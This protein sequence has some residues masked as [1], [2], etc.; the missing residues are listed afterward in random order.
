MSDPL[1]IAASIA[2]LAALTGK[3]FKAFIDYGKGVKDAR[4]DVSILTTELRTLSGM[5]TNLSLLATSLEAPSSNDSFFSNFQLDALKMIIKNLEVKLAVAKTDFEAS[6]VRSVI[7]K[8]RWPFSKDDMMKWV[9]EIRAHKATINL[10]LSADTLSNLVLCLKVQGDIRGELESTRDAMTVLQEMYSRVELNLERQKTYDYFLKINP[11]SQFETA[12]R[13]RNSDTGDWFIKHRV[14]TQWMVQPNS[15][16]WLTGIPGSGK[17]LLCGLL[18]ERVLNICT[19][20]TILAFSFCDY[21]DPETQA[22]GNILSSIALQIGLQKP[23]AFTR[24]QEYYKE[25]HPTSGLPRQ[26][27]IGKLTETIT[28]I[29]HLFTKVF[30]IVDGL[31]ECINNSR[32]ITRG[33]AQLASS[34]PN[35][36]IA[37]FSR[38][39]I[40]IDSELVP[41][42][43]EIEISAQRQDLERYIDGEM[44]GRPALRGLPLDESQKIKEALISKANGMFRW[45]TCQLDCLEGLGRIGRENALHE[46]PPTLDESYDRILN[47]VMSKRGRKVAQEIVRNTLHWVCYDSKCLSIAQICEAL[48]ITLSRG[49]TK[50]ETVDEKEILTYCS[51]LIRKNLKGDRFELAHFTVE[52]YLNAIDDQST[53]R[54]FRY[55]E[56]DAEVSL[57][58]VSLEH[59]LSPTFASRPVAERSECEKVLQRRRDHPFYGYAATHWPAASGTHDDGAVN[60]LLRDLFTPRKRQYLH[61]WLIE[62]CLCHFPSG[63]QFDDT[64]YNKLMNVI[65]FILRQDLTALH[66]AAM[67]CSSSL[68]RW[69]LSID[70]DVNAT[71]FSDLAPI[72]FA[73]LGLKVF[74]GVGQGPLLKLASCS[75]KNTHNSDDLCATVSTL[76]EHGFKAPEV[77]RGSV[78]KLALDACAERCGGSPFSAL[79]AVFPDECLAQDALI[80]IVSLFETDTLKNNLI[81]EVIQA[82]FSLDGGGDRSPQV[83]GAL[84][85]VSELVRS[86]GSWDT[87]DHAEHRFLP[88][89]IQDNDFLAYTRYTAQQNRAHDM[90]RLID[91][92]RFHTHFKPTGYIDRHHNPLLTAAAY[93][94][95]E[96]VRVLLQSGFDWLGVEEYGD[97][98]WHVAS[99]AGSLHVLQTLLGHEED[100]GRSLRVVSEGNTPLG[101]AFEEGC[102]SAATL[103]MGYCTSD[104]RFF[105]CKRNILSCAVEM[106]S[107]R[108][109]HEL[110]SRGAPDKPSAEDAVPL[111]FVNNHCSDEFVEELL[112]RY[113]KTHVTS[114][115]S[116]VFQA[117]IRQTL[118]SADPIL[119]SVE[120]LASRLSMLA[121][122]NHMVVRTKSKQHIWRLV[123]QEIGS[124]GN[125]PRSASQAFNIVRLI[126][127]LVQAGIVKSFEKRGYGSSMTAIYEELQV[128]TFTAGSHRWEVDFIDQASSILR[129]PPHIIRQPSTIA[130]LTR[131]IQ[132]RHYPI[133][134]WLLGL[135][136]PVHIRVNGIAP[137]EQ[138]CRRR[139]FRVFMEV[140]R[141]GES[142]LG[143]Q[144]QEAGL[145]ILCRLVEAA[146]E[147]AGYERFA[148]MK[149]R[150]VLDSGLC[151]DEKSTHGSRPGEPAIVM[152]ARLGEFDI[153]DLLLANGANIFAQASD[154][155]DLTKISISENRINLL[156]QIHAKAR[157]SS[158]CDWNPAIPFTYVF[159]DISDGVS[160]ANCSVLHLAACSSAVEIIDYLFSNGLIDNADTCMQSFYTP[161]HVASL[162][163]DVETIRCLVRHGASVDG[164]NDKQKRPI[165]LAIMYEEHDAVEILRILGAEQAT[166]MIPASTGSQ[167]GTT[168]TQEVEGCIEHGGLGQLQVLLSEDRPVDCLMPTCG[169]CDILTYAIY[170]GKSDIVVWL[171]SI[172]AIPRQAA[173]N[174]HGVF[175]TLH[176]AVTVSITG[177]CLR[178]LLDKA[179]QSGYA[180]SDSPV[181]PLHLA[182]LYNDVEALEVILDH[183]NAN[184]ERYCASISPWKEQDVPSDKAAMAKALTGATTSSDCHQLGEGWGHMSGGLMLLDMTSYTSRGYW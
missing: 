173:C 96:V 144:F 99:R 71:T 82:I 83:A 169:V 3:V 72:H 124:F 95:A 180:W 57:A 35:L 164:V 52:E 118:A 146:T 151:V 149:I 63:D 137:I 145:D 50:V 64:T 49:A 92:A 21:K 43:D 158:G 103:L 106:G 18:I 6:K 16:M 12:R 156:R 94:N 91:D 168:W 152:A 140:F 37:L 136:T 8:L 33:I 69:L 98:V 113:D 111:H 127:G 11:Q 101:S 85:L 182:C 121:P 176:Q 66:I 112:Q 108:L 134:R 9:D 24:L 25:L 132:Q 5:L 68:C 54:S 120:Q 77:T 47:K 81:H 78:G 143:C 177:F 161:L 87:Y 184:A 61:N 119:L 115:G 89:L 31:D 128:L 133:M 174:F 51:S 53:L 155:L 175:G 181:S 104:V 84:R 79:L 39:E 148:M 38:R 107:Q 131:A 62:F 32:E 154:G 170:Y 10:A 147:R 59:I 74:E 55:S 45:V 73:L 27:D 166:T 23:D 150:F 15:R 14:V 46:L 139:S 17:T 163:G 183:L 28:Y 26:I 13:L 56:S 114:D 162:F 93:D 116:T 160:F 30:L 44:K 7:Q 110:V 75:M 159:S 129:P 171:L 86:D 1:S 36:S 179:L 165:E 135:N 48:S 22:L 100:I 58:R 122:D 88:V 167:T 34:I 60:K 90:T 42:Y 153:V 76:I 41:E 109:F 105:Q 125:R 20:D 70:M 141:A 67:V 65:N 4:T 80:K 123:C 102:E 2:G 178:Q 172:G 29:C 40:E 126:S 138:A 130:F 117:Y 157:S 19:T 97:T 142:P